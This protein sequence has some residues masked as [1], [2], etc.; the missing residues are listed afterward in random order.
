[1]KPAVNNHK[2]YSF[3][4]P[5]HIRAARGWLWWT[6]DD[7]EVKSGVTRGAVSKYETG[8]KNL[9]VKSR[10]VL[11]NTFLKEGVELLPDGIRARET[12]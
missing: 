6:L 7:I 9:S 5:Q 11:Y 1:M 12:A 10:E 2:D 3:I 8:K 4:S